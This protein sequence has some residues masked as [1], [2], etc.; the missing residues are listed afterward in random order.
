MT[1]I[2]RN[3]SAKLIGYGLETGESIYEL[4]RRRPSTV[5]PKAEIASRLSRIL[6]IA[7]RFHLSNASR[8]AMY[9]IPATPEVTMTLLRG[10][11]GLYTSK[12]RENADNHLAT[13]TYTYTLPFD[14]LLIIFPGTTHLRYS[15]KIIARSG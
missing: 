1:F 15:Q 4:R 14:L 7:R 11:G 10:L 13:F 2:I 6:K 5:I 9:I 8:S 12:E 3:F